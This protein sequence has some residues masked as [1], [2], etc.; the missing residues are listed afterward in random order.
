VEVRELRAE[1]V[2][3]VVR[4]LSDAGPHQLMSEDSFRHRLASTPAE[5][6]ERRWVA[7]DR[8]E[9]VGVAGAS[10]LPYVE[11]DAT[12]AG[13][14]TVRADRRRRGLGGELFD[15]VLGHVRELGAQRMLAEASGDAGRDFLEQRDFRRTQTRRYS[16]VDPRTVEVARLADMRER[17]AAD[18]YEIV[19]L[20]ECRPEDVYA[21]DMATTHDVPMAVEFTDMPFDD[22]LAQYWSNPQLRHDGSFAVT[23]EGRPV[24]ITLLRSE[25]DRAMND[26][27]GTLR[28]H[29]GR[30]LAL[31]VKLHQLE[32][33]AR[34]GIV[35]VMT[36][37][38]ERNAPM[39]A[40]NRRLGYRPFLEMTTYLREQV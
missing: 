16:R 36:E 31:L 35:S 26:M 24:T 6:R 29:R 10:L 9:V 12:G 14:V 37:N 7:I 32:W 30:G 21:V 28:Q 8:G 27:T 13:G 33:A 5:A 11:D 1:D 38:D 17:K 3:G 18:R 15:L 34:D 25:G 19:P 40:V 20:A 22:W 4:L 23:H 39:L 2:A